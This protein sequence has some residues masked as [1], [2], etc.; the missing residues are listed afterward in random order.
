MTLLARLRDVVADDGYAGTFQSLS[1][2]RTALLRHITN[3]T[4]AAASFDSKHPEQPMNG[5]HSTPSD[6]NIPLGRLTHRV[7]LVAMERAG[8]ALANHAMLLAADEAT[9]L[10]PSAR[11]YLDKLRSAWDRAYGDWQQANLLTGAAAAAD[12]LAELQDAR[13]ALR[14]IANMPFVTPAAHQVA[15]RALAAGYTKADAVSQQPVA[16][17]DGYVDGWARI[18]WLSRALPVGTDLFA[19]PALGTEVSR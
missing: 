3:L 1:Q 13:R 10:S 11:Q 8:A 14:E 5:N 19:A 9:P 15:M 6:D 17:F 12:V 7:L 2:Y 4:A 16:T 18:K